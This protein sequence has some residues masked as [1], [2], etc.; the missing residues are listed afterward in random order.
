MTY[1][2]LF[3]TRSRNINCVQRDR[4]F[5]QLFSVCTQLGSPPRSRSDERLYEA[6]V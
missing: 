4:D 6:D 1:P 2:D 3:L 5:Y